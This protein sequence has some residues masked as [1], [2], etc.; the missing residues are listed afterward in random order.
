[1]AKLVDETQG[2]SCMLKH[3]V[4]GQV[5]DEV[6]GRVNMGIRVLKSGL[7]D[8]GGGISSL[9]G[10]CVVGAGVATLSLDPRDAAVLGHMLATG[11]YG[12]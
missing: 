6:L 7:N 4:K 11:I 9:G 1:M 12:V 2:E 8:K 5:L 10:R 3:V